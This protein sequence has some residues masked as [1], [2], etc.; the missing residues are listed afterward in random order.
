VTGGAGYI[1]SIAVSK[2]ML[3]GH[4]INVLDD[5]STGHESNLHSKADFFHGSIL[6]DKILQRAMYGCEAVFHFAGKALVEESTKNPD[7][8][9]L[10]N[11]EGTR[12]VLESMKKNS[13]GKLIFSSSCAVYGQTDRIPISERETPRPINPYG[14]SKLAAENLISVACTDF[15]SAMS[16]R[17]FNVG[18]SHF[19]EGRAL[20]EKHFPETHLA[21]NMFRSIR[22]EFEIFGM[23]FPTPDGTCVRDFVHVEDLIDGHI[24]ALENLVPNSH[25]II[26]LGSGIGHSILELIEKAREVSEQLIPY[27]ISDP[28]P[29]DPAEL[30]ADISLAREFL[31]WM[32][33]R[34]IEELLRDTWDSI[35]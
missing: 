19:S 34:K 6:D 17:Y 18:G 8:Y 29:G 26:N 3:S 31:K 35:S 32:P 25:T 12:T 28:R 22:N 23:D 14:E 21:P 30:I 15:L 5:L 24:L 10:I 7:L 4:S 16:L 20:F 1:G 33:S 2:L 13:V 9:Q 27:T 11:V